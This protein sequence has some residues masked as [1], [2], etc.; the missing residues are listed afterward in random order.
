[1][2]GLGDRRPRR[3]ARLLSLGLSRRSPSRVV[4]AAAALSAVLLAALVGG[5]PRL[6]P[7]RPPSLSTCTSPPSAERSSPASGRWSTSGSTPTP[8]GRWSG[9]SP[10][11]ATA[12]GVAGGVLAWLASRALPLPAT[13]L[14]PRGDDGDRGASCST[15]H[16]GRSP[17][18]PPAGARPPRRSPLPLLLRNP[19]VRNIALVV[20]LGAVVEALV[21]FL[22][23]GLAAGRFAAGGSL[24]GAFGAFHG[25]MSV[26]EPPAPGDARAAPPCATSASRARWPCARPSPRRARSSAPPSPASP[27]PLSPAGPTSRSRTRSSAPPTSCSTRR[28]PRPRSA[29]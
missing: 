20:R 4:P 11:G 17:R 16:G 25:G 18:R 10:P 2:G 26:L 23:K 8:R 24:L 29:A 7:R 5:R 28:C 1:M 22:F 21:D 3:G 19:Y 14:L 9:G 13:V 15:P 6:A 12:G 27:P